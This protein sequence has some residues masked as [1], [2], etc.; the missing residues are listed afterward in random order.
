MSYY[1]Q[2]VF[3]RKV[4]VPFTFSFFLVALH[5]SAQ[6][7]RRNSTT[8]PAVAVSAPETKDPGTHL[9]GWTLKFNEEFDQAALDYSKWLVHPPANL[10]P[11]GLQ[12]W[13]PDAIEL[14][15]DQ[16]HIVARK[17]DSGYTSGFL[18]TFGTFA[19]TYGRF[20]VRFHMPAGRGLEPLFQLLPIPNGDVPSIDVMNATGG[21]PRKALFTNRWLEGNV[22]RDYSG[23]YQVDD[24]SKGF[25]I[26]AVEWDEEKIIW[27]VDG[28][29]RFQSF[30]GVPHQPM[31]L[32]VSLAVGTPKAGEPDAQTRFPAAF[33]I[34]Y[35]RVFARP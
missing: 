32:A 26:V 13:S 12:T 11:D 22:D 28:N 17:S 1:L 8:K 2:R 14:F 10:I 33:D 25:H 21:D 23:S 35:I 24:L 29:E 6:T 18:T 15:A 3:Q 20:E 19:Q 34:D 16:A 4:A 30:E 5:V 27:T 31:Y 7:V 9:I